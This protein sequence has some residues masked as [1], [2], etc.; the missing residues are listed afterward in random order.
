MCLS[1]IPSSSIVIDRLVASLTGF[2]I[3]DLMA[4]C[5]GFVCTFAK[6]LFRRPKED[7]YC[8]TFRI[9]FFWRARS[10]AYSLRIYRTH[11]AQPGYKCNHSDGEMS[12]QLWPHFEELKHV[13]K[14]G[15]S[16]FRRSHRSRGLHFGDSVTLHQSPGYI[17][18]F[19]RRL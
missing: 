7:H 6:D 19:N 16:G 12:T 14:I 10:W 15:S 3:N 11:V 4:K 17:P 2:L 1:T 13:L 9:S 18:C 8:A 5:S